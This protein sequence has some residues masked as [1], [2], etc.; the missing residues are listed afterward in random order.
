MPAG[1]TA[2]LVDEDEVLVADGGTPVDDDIIFALI[3][4]GRKRR[5]RPAPASPSRYW[6]AP[7][8]IMRPRRAGAAGRRSPSAVIVVT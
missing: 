6:P 8:M 1:R 7:I 3:D 2:R 5:S 4:A